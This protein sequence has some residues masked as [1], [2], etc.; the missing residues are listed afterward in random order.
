M[1]IGVKKMISCEKK[2]DNNFEFKL[3]GN[4]QNVAE[5]IAVLLLNVKKQQPAVY[6]T[7]KILFDKN[8]KEG[9]ENV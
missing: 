5:E 2:E 3:K 6:M 7:A 1:K 8:D 4:A 9:K